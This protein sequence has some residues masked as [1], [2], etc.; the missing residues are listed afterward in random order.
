[1]HIALPVGCAG[2]GRTLTNCPPRTVFKVPQRERQSVQY[3][4]VSIVSISPTASRSMRP[5]LEWQK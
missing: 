5:I 4:G 2:F 1:M 3:P